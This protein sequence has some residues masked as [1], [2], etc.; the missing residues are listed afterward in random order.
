VISQEWIDEGNGY[1]E[2]AKLAQI[3][4]RLEAERFQNY[5]SSKSGSAATKVD[6]RRTWL[7]WTINAKGANTNGNGSG[8]HGKVG[9]ATSTFRRLYSEARAAREASE[10]GEN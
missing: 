7:N 9:T 3:D 8:Q 6:W 1:R 4:L 2:A 10:S 5:W